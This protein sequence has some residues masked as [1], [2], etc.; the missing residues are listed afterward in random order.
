MAHFVS[1][2]GSVSGRFKKGRQPPKAR[3][4]W[5]SR[6]RERR[7]RAERKK[8]EVVSLEEHRIW[9]KAFRDDGP[10]PVSLRKG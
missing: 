5:R 6:T 3:D 10:P 8:A 1:Y 2:L 4:L 7:E 9:S